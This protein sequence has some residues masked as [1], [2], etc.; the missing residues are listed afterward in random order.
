MAPQSCTSCTTIASHTNPDLL[1]WESEPDGRGT[2][3]LLTTTLSTIFL[4]TWVVI[5]P[6]VHR[7]QA[8][9]I[10]HKL[11]LLVKTILAPNIITAE[12]LQEWAQ[13]R[14]MVDYCAALSY[15]EFN[16]VHV[17]YISML[18]LHYETPD[19]N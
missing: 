13:C 1:A 18:A 8:Y 12:G 10:W 15:G 14:I 2:L 5:H 19:G 7:S 3:G 11:T 17:Y 4:C 16:P 6:L 9:A